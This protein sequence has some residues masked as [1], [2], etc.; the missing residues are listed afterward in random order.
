MM[1]GLN[2][3]A[4]TLRHNMTLSEYVFLSTFV[5]PSLDGPFLD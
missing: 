2:N 5:A 3:V 4:S 1:N